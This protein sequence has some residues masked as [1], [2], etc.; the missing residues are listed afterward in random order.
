MT[1]QSVSSINFKD[2]EICVISDLHIGVHQSASMWHDIVLDFARWLKPQLDD[3]GIRD[4]VIAGDVFHDRDEVSV[5][6]IHVATEFFKILRDFN[7]VILVGNHDAYYR[8]R[9]DVNSIDIFHD[10]SN[11]HIVNTV[12]AIEAF[13]KTI[14]FVPWAANLKDIPESDLM[15]GHFE[16]ASF[17]MNKNKICSHGI[18]SVDLLNKA[19]LVITGHFHFRDERNYS[20]GTIL[21]TGCP[22]QLDWSDCSTVKGIH[23]LDL[24]TLKFEF[25]PNEMS[26]KHIKFRLSEL[27]NTET[28][29]IETLKIEAPGNIINFLIDKEVSPDKVDALI[30]KVSSLHPLQ[31]RTEF[32][33][34]Q[35]FEIDEL[36]YEFTGVDI[37]EAISEF[38]NMI[39][40]QNK[41]EVL[42][43][44]LDLF[45]K[46]S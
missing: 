13:D 34:E 41:P 46:V 23:L 18:N 38:I 7:I 39:E 40:I 1:N 24:K 17:K 37:P 12:T 14:T 28:G 30:H 29:M 25:I 32:L 2:S 26:P 10:W 9:S 20:N 45:K 6:T 33:D 42:N 5:L 16:I 3:Q 11:I 15:F 31:L 21:Y 19:R 43:H 4:I 22:Y 35:Q 8:D 27:L 44:T 36:N